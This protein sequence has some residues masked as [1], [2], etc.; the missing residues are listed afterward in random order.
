MDENIKPSKLWMNATLTNEKIEKLIIII[1]MNFNLL[2]KF[3]F[4]S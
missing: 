3:E 1:S 4:G 2:F